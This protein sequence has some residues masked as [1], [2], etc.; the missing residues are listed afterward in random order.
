MKAYAGIGSRRTPET[1]L[2]VMYGQAALL[3]VRG[4]T[5]YSGGAEGADTAFEDGCKSAHGEKQ[6]FLPWNGASGRPKN[7][8][9]YP[10]M[11]KLDKA[12]VKEARE[13]AAKFHPYWDKLSHTVQLIHARNTLQVLGKDLATPVEFVLCWTDSEEGGGTSQALRIAK[14]RGIPVFNLYKAL[15]IRRISFF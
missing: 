12:V 9:D 5:L 15:R 7:D 1:Y 13:I 10:S 4:Y 3:A 6:I 11:D 2:N 14:D 8:P